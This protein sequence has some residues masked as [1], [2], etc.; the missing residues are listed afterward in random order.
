MLEFTTVLGMFAGAFIAALLAVTFV[1][2]YTSVRAQKLGQSSLLAF[3]DTESG[4]SSILKQEAVST[5]GVWSSL[6]L[7]FSQIHT[8]KRH[9]AEAALD[10]SPGRV[11]A[12]M[13]LLGTV[14]YVVLSKIG[15]LPS[16]AVLILA[17]GTASTPYMVILQRRAKRL[18]RF[19]VLFPDALDSLS[20]ALKAGFPL[21][22]AF[23]MLATEYPEPLASEIRRTREEWRLGVAWDGA[24]ENLAARIPVP[25]VRLFVAAVKMQNR[26]GGRLNDVLARLSETMRDGVALESEVRSISSHSRITGMVLTVMPLA[27]GGLMLV[28]NP[29]YMAAL[30]ERP[31]G[32]LM[33]TSAA[34]ANIAA[35]FI[36][37]RLAR[38]RL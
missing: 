26:M 35:H 14:S 12:G 5:I 34:V 38:V 18:A 27:I 8:L 19:S 29:Q 17:V 28:I 20:R 1:S 2:A 9:I 31:E 25:E 4:A 33:L 16:A 37:K 11:A 10:W 30:L 23:E 36:I 7:R 15:W 24:L 32:R 22:A 3:E 13:L 21:S 6:L